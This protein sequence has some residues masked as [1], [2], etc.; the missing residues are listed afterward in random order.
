MYIQTISWRLG[1][2]NGAA[3]MTER[4]THNGFN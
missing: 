3:I 1:L 4:P 2:Y